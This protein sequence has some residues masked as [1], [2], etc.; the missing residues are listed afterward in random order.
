M[1]QENQ[2][3]EQLQYIDNSIDNLNNSMADIKSSINN[4]GNGIEVLLILF[5]LISINSNIKKLTQAIKE[6]KEQ[7]KLY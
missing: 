6:S 7:N 5:V 1:N 2:I 3:V 4:S